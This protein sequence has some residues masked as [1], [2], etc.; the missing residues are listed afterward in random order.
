MKKLTSLLLAIVM[1]FTALTLSGCG[2]RPAFEAGHHYRF[3]SSPGGH[4]RLGITVEKNEYKMDEFT[5]KLY[6][7][8]HP[9]SLFESIFAKEKE[10]TTILPVYMN[11]KYVVGINTSKTDNYDDIFTLDDMYIIKEL[12]F[13]ESESSY[14]YYYTE[15][16]LLG[17][18]YNH[19]EDVKIPEEIL[20]D[21]GYDT[22]CFVLFELDGDSDEVRSWTIVHI[23][24]LRTDK[25]TIVINRVDFVF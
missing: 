18:N 5:V 7:G 6:V 22:L 4:K 17:V 15:Y 10:P 3:D 1:L 16:M 11:R 8:L 25:D 14:E 21:S 2:M 24:Y 23:D 19:S 9:Y 12:S 13:E 20:V